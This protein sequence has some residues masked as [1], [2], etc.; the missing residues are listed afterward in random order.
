MGSGGPGTR[1]LISCRVLKTELELLD[2]LAAKLTA[3]GGGD[4]QCTRSDVLR[5]ALHL[6][7]Q[8]ELPNEFTKPFR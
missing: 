8:Q 3:A 1:C 2:S 6:L 5:V 4:V 7:A